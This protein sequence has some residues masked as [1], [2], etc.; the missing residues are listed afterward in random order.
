MFRKIFT[1]FVEFIFLMLNYYK[2]FYYYKKKLIQ[3]NDI[4]FNI[5]IFVI[6]NIFLFINN[7]NVYEFYIIN[8]ISMKK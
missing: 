6:Y 1:I 4:I 8:D 2:H 3:K 5:I 7:T